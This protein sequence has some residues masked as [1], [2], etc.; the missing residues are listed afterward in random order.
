MIKFI[1][2]NIKEI[3]NSM[4]GHMVHNA[5]NN[6]ETIKTHFKYKYKFYNCA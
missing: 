5:E 4:V 6:I 3:T 1:L 2:Q